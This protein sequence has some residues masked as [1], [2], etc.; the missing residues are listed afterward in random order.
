MLV[1]KKGAFASI[2]TCHLLINSSNW[3]NVSLDKNSINTYS[4]IQLQFDF[5]LRFRF[6]E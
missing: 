1:D 5:R 6:G 4:L 3:R 2:N